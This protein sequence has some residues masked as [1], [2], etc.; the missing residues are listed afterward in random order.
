MTENWY[1]R[2]ACAEYDPELWFPHSDAA[3][4]VAQVDEAKAVCSACPVIDACLDWALEHNVEHGIWG[5]ATEAERRSIRRSRGQ[6]N[7]ERVLEPC[8]SLAAYRRHLRRG[9]GID[10]ACREANRVEQ[11]DKKAEK[12][13]GQKL[14]AVA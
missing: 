10:F 5:G 7:R 9:E 11:A 13:A 6:R 8:G 14:G 3:L 2:A 4:N 12:K 1:T